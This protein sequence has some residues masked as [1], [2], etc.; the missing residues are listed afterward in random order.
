MASRAV[1]GM[2]TFDQ[3]RAGHLS[4]SARPP[5]ARDIAA[6][7]IPRGARQ[8][9][10]PIEEVGDLAVAVADERCARPLGALSSPK[11][12]AS[13]I[14]IRAPSLATLSLYLAGN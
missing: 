6:M 12:G 13:I 4:V 2:E 7:S 5:R 3:A 14:R 11:T 8:A 10:A 1:F 9:I